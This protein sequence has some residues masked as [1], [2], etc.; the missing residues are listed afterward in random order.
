MAGGDSD[1]EVTE[2]TYFP[3]GKVQTVRNANG[4]VTTNTL[5]GLDRVIEARTVV[6]FAGRSVTRP[7]WS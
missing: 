6:A 5:D 3:S 1:D 7:W 4:A 2:Q